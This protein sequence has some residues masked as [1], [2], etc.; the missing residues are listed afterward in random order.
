MSSL[1][2]REK[3][4]EELLEELLEEHKK[5]K[6]IN[7]KIE[8]HDIERTDIQEI[9]SEILDETKVLEETKTKLRKIEPTIMKKRF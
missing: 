9:E 7:Q 5:L 1:T 8:K 6:Q 4:Y 3:R 2:K